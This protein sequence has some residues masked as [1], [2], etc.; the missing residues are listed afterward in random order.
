MEIKILEIDWEVDDEEALELLPTEVTIPNDDFV[1][2]TGQPFS[3]DNY[4]DE[5]DF[6]TDVEDFL[7]DHYEHLLRGFHVS[8]RL[9]PEMVKINF[10]V[11]CI[12]SY[13]SSME[14]PKEIVEDKAAVLEYLRKNIELAPVGELDWVNDLEP[15]EAITEY[16]VCIPDPLEEIKAEAEKEV[17]KNKEKILIDEEELLKKAILRSGRHEI[18]DFLGRPLT[19]D[20]ALSIP[21]GDNDDKKNILSEMNDCICQMPDDVYREYLSKY[22]I[23]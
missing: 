19:F 22:R 15:D 14:V 13:N 18:E 4:E 17:I 8:G 7:S 5:D 10:T 21:F 11:G 16:D 2:W 23:V 6:L 1:K 9:F 20:E 3:K 12:A